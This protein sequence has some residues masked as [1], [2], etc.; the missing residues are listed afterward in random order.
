MCVA[1]N[2]VATQYLNKG[3]NV[4]LADSGKGDERDGRC[5]NPLVEERA[6][7]CAGTGGIVGLGGQKDRGREGDD[8]A[9]SLRGF[10]EQ[11]FL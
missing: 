9:L 5:F 1:T 2:N 8:R 11:A 4:V 7:H 3:E 6:L 10:D